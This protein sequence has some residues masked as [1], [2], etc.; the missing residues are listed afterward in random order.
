MTV[1]E[2]IALYMA[3]SV[4]SGGPCG[5]FPP[6]DLSGFPFTDPLDPPSSCPHSGPAWDAYLDAILASLVDRGLYLTAN[7]C[8]PSTGVWNPTCV[9][10]YDAQVAEAW[11]NALAAFSGS[12][13]E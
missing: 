10:N 1:A 12:C 4:P 8:N 6:P 2:R 13:E 9:G 3:G 7:C 11:A 5:N